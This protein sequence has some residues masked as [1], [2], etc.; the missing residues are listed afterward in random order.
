M[1][2]LTWRS[3]LLGFVYLS[4]TCMVV[5]GQS[6]AQVSGIVRDQSGAVLPGVDVT[7]TQTAT[8]S[9]RTV[10]TNETG[11]YALTN[12]PVGPY[13]LDAALP[14]F[15]TFVQTGIVLQV[16]GNPVIN[17]NL[18]VGQV[19]EQ[20][21]VTADA[22]LVETRSTG[23]GQV[24][25]NVRVLELPLNGRQVTDLII[26]SGAAVGGGNQGTARTWPTDFISVGGGL[27]DGLTYLLDGGTHNDPFSNAN[28]PLPFPDA[29]QEF[30]VETSAMPAQYG[31][32][33]SGAVNSVTKSGS[34]ELH[35]DLFEFVRNKVFNA[36]NAFS[37]TRDGLKRN[38]FGG[39]VGGP[40]VKNKLFFFGGY[41]GTIQ[42]SEANIIVSYVPTPQML[43]GD[44]TGLASPACNGGRQINLRAPFI[45]N[46]IDPA[47]FSKAAVTLAT[48]YL[49]KPIDDCGQ[50]VYG[51]RENSD[52]KMMVGKIDYQWSDNHSL[53]GRY[54]HGTLFTPNNYNGS[55]NLSLSIPDYN[56]GFHSFVLGDT[57]SLS[58]R[59]VSSFRGTVL[60]T[61]ND[62]SLQQDF[63]NYSDLGVKNLYFPAS[64]KH[65]VRLNVAGAFTQD[66][67]APG[68]T[69]STVEQF[70]E[71]LT[72]VRGT[73]QLGFGANFIHSNMNY[74]SGTWTSG[75]FSFNGATTGLSLADLMI[76]KPNEWRQDQIAAQYLRQNYIGLYLQDTWKATPKFT[77]N[78]GLRWEPYFW[79][80]DHR[81]SSAQYNKKWFDQGLRSTVF[82]NAPAGILF[83]G[84]AQAA[85][86]GKSEHSAAWMHFAPRAGLAWD[87]KGDGLTVVRAAY[88]IFFDYPHFQ[89]IGGIRNTPPRGGLIQLTNPG[90]G[91]DDPWQGY[92]GGNP[93][94][95][96]LSKDVV[97][98]AAGVYTVIPQDAKTSYV[99]QWNLSFQK[100]IGMDWLVATNYLGSSVIHQ[101]Y[102]HE[103]NP[104][105]YLP[106]ASCVLGGRTFSPCSTTSNTQQR[107]VLSLQNPDQGQY[108][109][110]IVEVD[111]GGTR[112][113]NGLVLS[114][115]RRRVR[116]VTVQGNY[117]WSHCIDTGYTDIIQTNGVQIPERRGLNRGNCELDRRHNFN[118]STV[119][120]TPQFANSV[121]RV[122]GGGWRVSGIV[123]MLSGPMLTVNTGIDQALTGTVFSATGG[124]ITQ[125]D[126]RPN[127][128]LRSP[129]VP[130]K[131]IANGW[132]NPAAFEQPALG[133]YGSLGRASVIGPGSVRIDIGL[134]RIFRLRE[135]QSVEFRAEAFNVANH[136]NACSSISGQQGSP[137][138]MS[139]NLTDATFGRVLATGDPR[140]MQMA[141][142]FVF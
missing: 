78:G 19:S 83:P 30:K 82:T 119:Y 130:N 50:T 27:N 9:K 63:Y 109:S 52:E 25:D 113:Y 87:P 80:Y 114:V 99:N 110:N 91:F 73:H 134:V 51:R 77:I 111:T 95:I 138:C 48:K 101:M 122:L 108:F 133:T 21:E 98:P 41:Q 123:R 76:G 140:I 1:N 11:S 106:G 66:V 20:V 22:T 60:R 65:Y 132:I 58:P 56:R 71:D 31:Q 61:L 4:L 3:A 129:Y 29:L 6:T 5:W 40:I 7:A 141:L 49:P 2:L 81:A 55:N 68:V 97:F 32:H 128:V 127:Q 89:G 70:S 53:F 15:R 59:T 33:S 46:R 24:I 44:F 125:T 136:V 54:E 107:R 23:V 74:T 88:G 100:Q 34:N 93:L 90:G 10:V 102:E 26:L 139:T 13:R 18:E 126:Q 45:N 115:Q 14:G 94:P 116:G 17:I 62:K 124:G 104:A 117:T 121:A 36:R 118:M 16:N 120:E 79:P 35:G 135:K 43:A 12:L 103:A 131:S 96:I 57:Y 92:P 105:V 69:N 67:S 75:R 47:M 38:Q 72:S 39:V 86:I 112:S 64:F 42:R 8:G 85:N 137:T 37:P 84:D 28:L 142:K